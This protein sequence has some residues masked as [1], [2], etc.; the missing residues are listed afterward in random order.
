LEWV[1]IALGAPFL[2][3]S[4]FLVRRL[5]ICCFLLPPIDFFRTR[6]LLL[7]RTKFVVVTLSICDGGFAAAAS[8]FDFHRL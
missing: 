4:F 2:F 7:N 3:F 5:A 6:N 8:V 1:H